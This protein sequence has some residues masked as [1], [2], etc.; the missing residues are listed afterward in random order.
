MQKYCII[1]KLYNDLGFLLLLHN[2]L[3][4]SVSS[5]NPPED[6]F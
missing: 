4:I 2:K 6:V 1:Y 3:A 5:P